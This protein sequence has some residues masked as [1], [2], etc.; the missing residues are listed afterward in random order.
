M[1][2][3][4]QHHI[5]LNSINYSN[6]ELNSNSCSPSASS[7]AGCSTPSSTLSNLHSLTKSMTFISC[8][9][10]SLSAPDGAGAALKCTGTSTKVNIESCSFIS[11][12]SDHEGGAI[13]TSSIHT[14]DVK[15]SIFYQCSTSTT[16]DNE[17]SGAIW[18]YGI[19]QKL[20]LSENSFISCTSNASG[21]ASIIQLCKRSLKGENVINSC[22]YILCTATEESPEG[23]AVWIWENDALIGIM[24]C[25]FSRCSSDYGG[26]LR[27][28]CFEYEE[29]SYPIRFC[30]FN[31]N[32]GIYGNDAG[33]GIHVPT[34]E[35]P[36]LLFCFS[37]S[38]QIRLGYHV[39]ENWAVTYANWLSHYNNQAKLTGSQAANKIQCFFGHH[40]ILEVMMSF[41][42]LPFSY[43]TVS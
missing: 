25:L 37:T 13:H 27:H 24:D 10:S 16:E 6:S 5:T 19:Q 14:F 2:C 34:S 28:D 21:G 20:S 1:E 11:C 4:R 35:Y 30:F 29:R 43:C 18:I 31:K 41:H 15:H 22:N 8:T 40:P 3:V 9:W 17:G 12:S 7:V 42:I 23:G 38:D 33:I 39:N 26:A 36:A 32:S